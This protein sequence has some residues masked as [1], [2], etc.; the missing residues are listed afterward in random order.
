VAEILAEHGRRYTA[1][2][3]ATNVSTRARDIVAAAE[4]AAVEL[5]KARG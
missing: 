5:T 1:F 2:E 3:R 4:R